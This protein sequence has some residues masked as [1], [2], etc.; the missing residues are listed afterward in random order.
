MDPVFGKSQENENIPLPN[1][2]ELANC[3]QDAY[4]GGKVENSGIA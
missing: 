3:F 2:D 1:N 4:T